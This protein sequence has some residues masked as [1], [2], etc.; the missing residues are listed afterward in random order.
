MSR[1][2][3]EG[4]AGVAMGGCKTVASQLACTVCVC[5]GRSWERPTIGAEDCGIL[6]EGRDL[7]IPKWEAGS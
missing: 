2:G 3:G 7:G 6:K 5:N 4:R 1:A